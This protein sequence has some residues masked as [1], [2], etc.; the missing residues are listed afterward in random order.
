M[1]LREYV[2]SVLVVSGADSFNKSISKLLSP[3][4]YAPVCYASSVSDARRHF[5]NRRFDF[6]IINMSLYSEDC[7]SFSIDC[8]DSQTSVVLL[9]VKKEIHEE[10]HNKVSRY[11]VFTI[12][13]PTS[14]SI[15]SQSLEWMESTRERLRKLEK[16]TLS[17]NE[18]MEEIRLVNKAK[19]MLID[20]LSMT[21]SD[22]HHYIEK[23][24]M[25]ACISKREAAETIIKE[26]SCS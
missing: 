18:R 10:I 2:Y 14:N 8:C 24:A 3:S 12:S 5:A 7:T 20:K 19:W 17:I 4:K 16:K 11:G 1:S 25:N 23:S 13:K 9:F 22:A 15:V 26:H 6:V 21:E